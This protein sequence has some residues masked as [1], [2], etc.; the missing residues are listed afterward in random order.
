MNYDYLPRSVKTLDGSLQLNG[1]VFFSGIAAYQRPD[2]S[3]SLIKCALV[4]IGVLSMFERQ[5]ITSALFFAESDTA[6]IFLA[7]VER[8]LLCHSGL[9]LKI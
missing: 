5:Y 2:R 8:H 4:R 1:H 6:D 7:E 3:V 9:Q